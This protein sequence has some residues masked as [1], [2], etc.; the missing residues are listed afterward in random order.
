MKKL[1]IQ[2]A[3]PLLILMWFLGCKTTDELI[4]E[5]DNT[6]LYKLGW[7]GN[8]NLSDVPTSTKF[9]LS[10]AGNLPESIDISSIMP[11]VGNQGSYGTC[12]SWATGYYAK[13]AV[14][15]LAKGYTAA[16]LSSSANQIS[17]KDLFTS[18]PEGSGKGS[19]CDGSA[20]TLNF[21][22]LLNRGAATLATVPYSN[23]GTCA[24]ST[25]QA[26][27]TS[28]A[29]KHKIKN[30]RTIEGSVTAIK[31]Q[32]INKVPVV[33]GA[34]LSDNFMTWNS[35]N[36]LSSNTT[37]N[38]VGKHA[39]HALTIV[40]YDDKKGVNGAFKVINS[41]G[42]SWGSKGYIWV[43]Y[44]FMLNTFLQSDGAGNKVLM[45][46]SE[47]TVKPNPTPTPT[48]TPT[49]SGVEL[50]A[51]VDSDNSQYSQ[52]GNR[53]SR[54]VVWNVYND[55]TSSATPQT[56]WTV[57]YI[58][59]NALNAND[60]GVL[61]YYTFTTKNLAVNKYSCTGSNCSF[62]LAI[63]SGSS[64][65]DKL[66]GTDNGVLVNYTMPSAISGKYYLV[67]MADAD[68][69]FK[70]YD[71][72]D[73]FF[74]TTDKPIVFQNGYSARQ[75]AENQASVAFSFKNNLSIKSPK[76]LRKR[77]NTAISPT[78]L[79]EYAPDEIF[80]FLL[81]QKKSGALAKKIKS[82]ENSAQAANVNP[83]K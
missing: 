64:F 67:M 34:F 23:L 66:F 57:Y 16:Q 22:T 42:T 29:A 32:L 79:N 53:L 14:E 33:L 69:A 76:E 71:E 35:D 56:P 7:L 73:N 81:E 50:S 41:W 4:P 54:A 82:Y 40:G 28:D 9:G 3:G 62:N 20:Y 13:T 31:Q 8:D 37:Y 44:N 68:G 39:G 63:P 6:T 55:G 58:Y 75:G 43:D 18:L 10:S 70:E 83:V 12:V 77:F 2:S 30:Y 19:N 59:Y 48:P 21:E 47:S 5:E 27:W 49:T 1:L 60:Y 51:W 24:S 65:S 38:K 46:M 74:Y 61:F 80:N 25:V 11:P 78:T 36:V 52:T 17:P 72:E 26:T 15:G 45:T